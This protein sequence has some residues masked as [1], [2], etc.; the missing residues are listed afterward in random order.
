MS[1]YT[2]LISRLNKKTGPIN[3]SEIVELLEEQTLPADALGPGSVERGVVEELGERYVNIKSYGAKGD[4]TTDD[5][6]AVQ[7]WANYIATNGRTGFVPKGTYKLTGTINF[8]LQAGWGIGGESRTAAV[9]KQYTN[10]IP[11]FDLGVGAGSALHSVSIGGIGF[12]YAT[13]QVGNTNSICIHMAGMLYNSRLVNMFFRNAY[14]GISA[15]QNG[16]SIWGTLFSSLWFD[17][18]ITGGYIYTTGSIGAWPN[19]NFDSIFGDATNCTTTLFVLKG[20]NQVATNIEVVM[21][22]NGVQLIKLIA[23]S[24]LKIGAIKMEEWAQPTTDAKFIEIEN[25][26]VLD[27]DYV[28]LAGQASAGVT[29][30]RAY[31]FRES[32]GP[33]KM[34]RVGRLFVGGNTSGTAP[35]YVF[36]GTGPT[37]IESLELGSNSKLTRASSSTAAD[38]VRVRNWANGRLSADKG[39]ADYTIAL[40]DPTEI[41]Y[42]TTLTADRT[43][44]LPSDVES[45]FGGLRYRIVRDASTLGAFNLLIKNG[46]TTVG[47]LGSASKSFIEVAWRRV[48]SG[49]GWRV[50]SSGSLP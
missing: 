30:S 11:I 28:Y 47:T 27:I 26:G 23:G 19:N 44:S 6:A 10:N 22:V 17:R 50:I 42:S 1:N 34:L 20:Y 48:A 24:Q 29:G 31:L 18:T 37:V 9:F 13:Q 14:L 12:D 41:F 39:D 15:D 43:I 38:A 40:G 2:D 46:A 8:P 45:N 32:G 7:A 33:S 5:T 21:N 35:L 16:K 4:G 49:N 3:L 36:E 25:G